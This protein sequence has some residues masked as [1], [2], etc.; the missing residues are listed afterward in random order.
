VLLDSPKSSE[1][2]GGVGWGV[3]SC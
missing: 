3:I 2:A 1:G